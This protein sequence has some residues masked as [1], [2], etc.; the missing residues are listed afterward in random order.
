MQ[1]PEVG[2]LVA[3][4]ATEGAMSTVNVDSLRLQRFSTDVE[5]PP[6]LFV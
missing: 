1:A 6:I 3:E 4:Q 5:A 2:R